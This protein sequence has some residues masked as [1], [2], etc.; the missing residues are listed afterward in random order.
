[1]PRKAKESIIKVS[2]KGFMSL[3]DFLLVGR[4]DN[5]NVVDEYNTGPEWIK[6]YETAKKQFLAYG[7]NPPMGAF[8]TTL[9]SG[10]GGPCGILKKI[11]GIESYGDKEFF[12]LERGESSQENLSYLVDKLIWWAYFVVVPNSERPKEPESILE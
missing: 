4:V 1:M 3:K 9:R 12:I 7:L 6:L 11:T 2:A 5:A 8:V 10:M